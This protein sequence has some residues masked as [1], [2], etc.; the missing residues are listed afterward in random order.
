LINPGAALFVVQPHPAGFATEGRG[1]WIVSATGH[2]LSF[3]HAGFTA[4]SP[5]G[6]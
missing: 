1:Y 3:G 6:I 4:T 5:A 2:V